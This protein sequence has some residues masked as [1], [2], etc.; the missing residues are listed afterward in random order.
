[1]HVPSAPGSPHAG[2]CGAGSLATGAGASAEG[3]SFPGSQGPD[4]CFE[5]EILWGSEHKLSRPRGELLHPWSCERVV[6]L[7]GILRSHGVWSC[8]DAS[9]AGGAVSIPKPKDFIL[10]L[11]DKIEPVR[12]PAS[13]W[14]AGPWAVRWGQLSASWFNFSCSA[15]PYDRH[16]WLCLGL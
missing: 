11:R 9:C 14:V 2:V 10:L 7:L 1:M 8:S 3:S 12:K 5:R 4:A 15:G 6:Q 16:G 13:E